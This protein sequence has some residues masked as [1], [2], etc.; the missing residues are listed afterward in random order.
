MEGVNPDTVQGK[1]F[2]LLIST[3]NANIKLLDEYGAKIK[4]DVSP[5]YYL[6]EIRYS[7]AMN[8]VQAVFKA[9]SNEL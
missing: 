4:D 8:E 5:E 2:E 6:K 3:I 7:P 9:I 1:F